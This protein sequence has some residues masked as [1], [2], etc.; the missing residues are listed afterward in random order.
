[1][2]FAKFT[3]SHYRRMMT[4][5]KHQRLA[6][7]ATT[8]QKYYRGHSVHTLYAGALSCR[9]EESQQFYAVWGHYIEASNNLTQIAMSWSSIREEVSDIKHGEEFVYDDGYFND[10][11]E[12][13][14]NALAGA[15]QVQDDKDDGHSCI[16]EVSDEVLPTT[17][18]YKSLDDT[19]G[20][21]DSK[22]TWLKFQMTR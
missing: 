20:I 9:L 22:A 3:S 5:R 11:D 18:D 19:K 13:L 21:D 12:Q 14:S 17:F 15:L 10:T 6:K 7:A 16:E 1:M 8:I 4:I 2:R